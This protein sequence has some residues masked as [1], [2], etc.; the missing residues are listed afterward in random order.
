MDALE[1]GILGD[2]SRRQISELSTLVREAHTSSSA[3]FQTV[4]R[5]A[6]TVRS[7]GA[8]ASDAANDADAGEGE[9]RKAICT[10]SCDGENRVSLNNKRSQSRMQLVLFWA[11][12]SRRS[13]ETARR[14]HNSHAYHIVAALA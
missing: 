5:S 11:A 7:L 2:L 12:S 1:R 14:R 3:V 10:H 8:E 13:P 9:K 6:L 4:G